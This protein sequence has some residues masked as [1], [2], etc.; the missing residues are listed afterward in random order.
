MHSS[1]IQE[2]QRALPLLV[3]DGSCQLGR[4]VPWCK[5]S[6]RVPHHNE[7]KKA[8]SLHL[9]LTHTLH[10]SCSQHLWCG[11]LKCQSFSVLAHLAQSGDPP[12][13]WGH[14]STLRRLCVSL[15][16]NLKERKWQRM[17]MHAKHN[18]QV[19]TSNM[20]KATV[21]MQQFDTT[22]FPCKQTCQGRRNSQFEPL[23]FHLGLP[24]SWCPG[25]LL[26][27]AAVISRSCLDGA[28]NIQQPCFKFYQISTD[29][30]VIID[31]Q[32]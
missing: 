14:V 10:T 12:K 5:N 4:C 27:C 1:K 17:N 31:C 28:C 15:C 25:L 7:D 18:S 32:V 8:A 11:P 24:F 21:Q 22:H 29:A 13:C 26:P 16:L 20:C 6:E 2:F 3:H 9:Q 19:N 23:W 30:P